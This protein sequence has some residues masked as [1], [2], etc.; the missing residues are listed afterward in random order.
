MDKNK[1][2]MFSSFLWRYMERMLAQ[3]V[4][5]LVSIVLARI[6]L[7]KEYG[8]VAL[9]LI[10][11]S[12]ANVLVSSGFGDALIQK[13]N[14]E[15]LDYST[16]FYC[17]LA[18]SIVLYCLIYICSPFLSVVLGETI[19]VPV[20]R[21]MALKIPLSSVATIQHAYV[22]KHM[23]FRKFFFATLIGTVI[24]G[25][26]GIILAY[27]GY[28]VWALVYQYLLNSV[29]D[30]IVLLAILEWK[31][32]LIFSFVVAK[33]LIGNAVKYTLSS[34]VNNAYGQIYNFFIGK[35]Y[36]VEQLAYYNRGNQFPALVVSNVDIA[37]AN[38]M[39]PT[40]SNVND[41]DRE[42]KRLCRNA[43]KISAYC[44]FPLIL[45]MF[46]VSSDLIRVLLTDKWIEAVYY[47][48]IGCC[49]N[50]FQPIQTINWQILKAK[51]KSGLCLKLEIVKKL[52]GMSTLVISIPYGVKIIALSCLINTMISTYINM[53]FGSK[54]IGYSVMEQLKDVSK[55]FLCSVL[56]GAIVFLLGEIE[57]PAVFSLLLQV[58]AG[59]VVYIA[60]SIWSK[61]DSFFMILK[62]L[63]QLVRGT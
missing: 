24:S 16:L 9:V 36:S 6:L 27:S 11:I 59:V 28:G 23:L 46:V 53:I 25:I 61:N 34:L 19:L 3:I 58:I 1:E 2:P 13:K 56:M 22:S 39:F 44:I 12:L 33:S 35:L 57:I 30:V 48:R 32:R 8:V 42:M 31:P 29:I 14:V 37:F 26:V 60:F 45:G 20:I 10:F 7:P 47:L 4:S 5:F 15:D 50:I 62:R 18:L 51:G 41:S 54:M 63:K 38:V 52:I 43:L 21:V 55:T 17:S 40:L 49:V